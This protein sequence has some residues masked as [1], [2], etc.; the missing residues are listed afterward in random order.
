MNRSDFDFD[1][2]SGPSMPPP[3]PMPV[4]PAGSAPAAPRTR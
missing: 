2:V 1:V 4:P 3:K